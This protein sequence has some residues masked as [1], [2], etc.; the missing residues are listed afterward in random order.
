MKKNYSFI[1]YLIGAF[2]LCLAQQSEAQRT[3][4]RGFVDAYSYY[5]KDKLNFG[6]GEQDLFITS[7]ITERL[8]FLGETVFKYSFDSPTDFDI[9]VERIILKYNYAGNHSV[10]I[11]K[12]HTPIN[13]WNDTYHHGRV[14]F[15]TVERPLVFSEGIIPLHTTGISLQGQNLGQLRFGYDVMVGNGIGSGD[16]A[17][18]DL[19]KSLTVA[20]HVKPVDGFRLGASLYHDVISKGSMMHNHSSGVTTK[21]LSKITQN[22]MTAS[23][24]YTDSVFSK[25]YELLAESSMAMNRSD[26][27]GMQRTVASYAYAGFRIT[28]KIIPYI[29]VDDIRYRNKE[30]YYI[31]NNVR[32]FVGGLRYEMSYLAVLKLEYQHTQRPIITS[33]DRVIFQVAVGF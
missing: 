30:V 25:R 15:P 16:I 3:Q 19:F 5:Q 10:L 29:R 13:Y 31:H 6:L 27:L 32:S 12:H 22:I 18:N 7:E 2:V 8:S 33:P 4:I 11:G 28:D 1:I 23:V 24:S 20:A 26:S 21:I 14:F 9:S 17:D